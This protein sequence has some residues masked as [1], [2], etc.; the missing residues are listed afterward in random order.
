MSAQLTQAF[1]RTLNLLGH[2]NPSGGSPQ[3]SSNNTMKSQLSWH[4]PSDLT[5]LCG[6]VGLGATARLIEGINPTQI[7]RS[8]GACA[9]TAQ[10]S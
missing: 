3:H 9:L 1:L 2:F 7:F 4:D 6:T 8:L 5:R 10:Q